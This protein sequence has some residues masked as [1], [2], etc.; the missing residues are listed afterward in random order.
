[1]ANANLEI[2]A[3]LPMVKKIWEKII[4]SK[5]NFHLHQIWWVMTQCSSWVVN[6]KTWWSVSQW[7]NKMVTSSKI[8]VFLWIQCLQTWTRIKTFSHK[9]S[10]KCSKTLTITRPSNNSWC[11]VTKSL[12][13]WCLKWCFHRWLEVEWISIN[14]FRM[15]LA[16]AFSSVNSF[17]TTQLNS[18]SNRPLSCLKLMLIKVS[19]KLSS[20]REKTNCFTM[21]LIILSKMEILQMN[22]WFEVST[23]THE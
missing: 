8:Q 22:E 19:S 9:I 14:S 10:F 20:S 1:M 23:G 21:S 15:A 6:S 13:W 11:K 17:M 4:L 3:H 7:V 18:K 2:N 12:K 16:R 5:T